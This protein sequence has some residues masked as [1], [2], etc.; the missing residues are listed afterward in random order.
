[1]L[2]SRCWV[3]GSLEEMTAIGGKCDRESVMWPAAPLAIAIDRCMPPPNK[4]LDRTR[5]SKFGLS[6][7]KF[8]AF[9]I[10]GTF[11]RWTVLLLLALPFACL[12]RRMGDQRGGVVMC[13]FF[14]KFGQRKTVT[15]ALEE[16]WR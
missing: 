3:T 13:W 9:W 11:W 2:T 6:V 10:G 5:T 12:S 4:V 7:A 16:P 14:V 8:T 15:N 1:M